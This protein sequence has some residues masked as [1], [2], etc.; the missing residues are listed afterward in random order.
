MQR[1]RKEG[2]GGRNSINTN[3]NL[4]LTIIIVLL[5]WY[6]NTKVLSFTTW[7]GVD[8]NEIKAAK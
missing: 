8:W 4:G 5:S 3:I 7:V 1:Y 2:K 6:I